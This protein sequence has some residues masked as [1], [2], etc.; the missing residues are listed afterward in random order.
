MF[1]PRSTHVEASSQIALEAA[2]H[3]VRALLDRPRQVDRG[4]VEDVVRD[5]AQ[6]L[7]L[8]VAQDR[9]AHEQLVRVLRTSPTAG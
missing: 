1:A 5:L 7:Q 3:A 8:V 6:L 4:G 2:L 9:L